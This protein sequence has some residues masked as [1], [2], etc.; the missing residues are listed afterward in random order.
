M[1]YRIPEKKIVME[2][3]KQYSHSMI[4]KFWTVRLVH[5]FLLIIDPLFDK[6]I[7]PI[8]FHGWSRKLPLKMELLYNKQQSYKSLL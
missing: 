3:S 8:A 4:L 5:F 2:L 1:R 6:L 7:N